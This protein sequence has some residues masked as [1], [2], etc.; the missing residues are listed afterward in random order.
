MISSVSSAQFSGSGMSDSLRPD[1]LQH[2]MLP[3]P[4][5]S[6]WACSNSCQLSWWCHPTISSSVGPFSSCLQNE[7]AL[8]IRWLKFWSFNFSIS[9]S[10]EYSGLISFRKDWFDILAVQG[11]LKSLLKHYSSKASILQHSD[12]IIV[13]L[14]H[15]FMTTGETIAFFQSDICQQSN[16][17]GF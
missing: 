17:F 6:P 11:T 9:L 12:F 14:S 8:C 4:T 3:C 7:S 10:N 13:Q 2:T 1:G 5:P 15:P 16:V